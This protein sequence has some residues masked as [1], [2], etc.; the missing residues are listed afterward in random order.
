VG[1]LRAAGVTVGLGS[2]G[3]KENNNLDLVEEMKFASLLHKLSTSD[4]AAG[5]PWD[6]LAMATVD[7]ARATGLDAVTGTLQPGRRADVIVVRL[8][9]PA[10]TPL[11]HGADF[12]AAAHLVFSCTGRDVRDVWVDGRALL[13]DRAPQT[14]DVAAVRRD[15]QAAAEE[16]LARRRALTDEPPVAGGA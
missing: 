3:E 10:T 11:L 7:G 13:R 14:F 5:D 1:A 2:D 6:V 16:L 15:A 12:N 4:A 9:E 8:D